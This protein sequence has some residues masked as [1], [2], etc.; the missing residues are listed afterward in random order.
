MSAKRQSKPSIL[1][2]YRSEDQTA[3]DLGVSIRL[4]RKWRQLREGPAYVEFGRRFYY[5]DQAIAAWLKAREIQ[6]VRAA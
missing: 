3:A 5:P 6:P 4:L 1:G 2:G